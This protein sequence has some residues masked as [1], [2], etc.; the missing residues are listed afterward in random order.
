MPNWTE[1]QKKV[2]DLRN[3]N[4]LVSAAAGSG[5]TAVLVERIVS[6][7]TDEKNKIDIDHLLIVTFTNAAAAEMRERIGQAI[8][9]K[10]T[11]QL[12]N[13]HLQK[14]QTLIH[15]AQITTIHSFCLNVIRNNFNIIELDPSF[16]VGDETEL[17]LLKSDI[18]S[19]LLEKHYEQKD[20]TFYDFIESY[21]TGKTDIDIEN[22]ILQLYTFSQS[23]PEPK[24]WLNSLRK[25]FDINTVEDLEQTEW[26]KFLLDYIKEVTTEVGVIVDEAL[27]MCQEEDGAY[28]YLPT[29]MSDKALIRNLNSI[30]SY[31]AYSK[32]LCSLTW[33]PLS[34]KKDENV[35]LE[36]REATK[37]LR[38]EIKANIDNIRKNYFFQ[39]SDG[40][41]EDI[42]GSKSIMNVLIDLT[43]E[44]SQTYAEAKITKNILDFN[45]LEHK[46]LNILAKNNPDG[47]YSPTLTAYDLSEYYEEIV[48]D[49]YQDSN[50]VQEILL[51]SISREKFGQPN[52]FMVGDVK[53]SI[54]KF[55]LAKPEIFM[56]KYNNYLENRDLYYLVDLHKNFRSR[57]NIIECVNFIFEQIMDIK[58]GGINYN[59]KVALNSGAEFP[60]IDNNY[61]T[62][63][64]IVDLSVDILDESDKEEFDYTSKEFEAKA[65]AGKIKSIVASNFQVYDKDIKSYRNVKYK[66]IVILLRTVTGWADIFESVLMREGIAAHCDTSTGYF[67]TIEIQTV[68][69][70]LNIIDN[71]RQDIALVAVLKSPIAQINSE[72]LAI[73]K[74]EFV[75]KNMYDCVMNYIEC[76]SKKEI[77][78]KLADFINLLNKFRDCVPYTSIH[79]LI[80]YILDET[81]YYNYV[82]AMP[83]GSKRKAN[84]DMLIERAIQFEATSYKGL[85]NFIRYIDRIRDYQIDFGEA[86]VLGDNENVVKI[87]SIHKSKG[88]E[89]PIVFVSGLNK[90]FNNQ[91]ARSKIVIHSDLGI[92]PNY[93]D[94][95]LRVKS[96]TL[97]KKII[98]KRIVLENLGEELRIL[99]VALTRAKERLILTGATK[100][101][102]KMLSKYCEMVKQHSSTKLPFTLLSSA[103]TYLDW[104]IPSLL[105][106]N[107]FDEI[108][109]EKNIY[110]NKIFTKYS[111][112]DF[113]TKI[114][115]LSQLVTKE[116]QSQ[117]NKEIIKEKLLN[118]KTEIIDNDLH[119][120]I[121]KRLNWNYSHMNEVNLHAKMTV[122]E[123]KVMGQNV[124]NQYS[125]NLISTQDVTTPKFISHVIEIKGSTR[126]TVVHK[127]MQ[128]INFSAIKTL[129]DVDNQLEFLIKIN[130]LTEQEKTL[131]SNREIYNF[132][133][134]PLANRMINAEACGKIFKEKQFI[135]G[136]KACD[137]NINF[138]SNELVLVQGIIDVYFE[139][140]NNI[141]LVDYKTDKVE[142]EIILIDRYKTQLNYYQ[143][144]VEQI[145]G[146]KVIQKI[147]YSFSMCRE[148]LL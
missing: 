91:D 56:E 134:S 65:I 20:E 52:I 29:L 112:A 102:T 26:M 107:S 59:D 31:E 32:I 139:E 98:S 103:T 123:L 39:L 110:I 105:R 44:F 93:I 58:L 124:D 30:N 36:K 116:L 6:I 113:K 119:D 11:A 97:I 48:I 118:W 106:H 34:P 122:T 78:N 3:G 7:I 111:K 132:I 129:K 24:D 40:M 38:A 25:A 146:R 73:I 126:G 19:E 4:I 28:M 108:L 147:I 2:V 84:I 90:E 55:R 77:Q 53:Q 95:K 143:K 61:S 141:V 130:K 75:R 1:E 13:S 89:F 46:A 94:Y 82:S 148:I 120:E 131:V 57:K 18:V 37:S 66:D 35:S 83:V 135:I 12:S 128:N 80:E 63:L 127:V 45:D 33:A 10:L 5:K 100:N 47:S 145:T 109:K 49:E 114:I 104:I 21:S 72:E 79:H 60:P 22:L 81:D 43:I 71:P 41:I 54:Y 85:F 136:I 74:S 76:G 17:K 9:T 27:A 42:M 64:M 51:N 15:N 96:P 67:S 101:W 92:G 115:D 138:K 62:E 86:S 23:Y 137:I 99:Y 16:R 69:S 125:Q 144:A 140:D 14:Q 142:N 117:I 121:E 8:E 133:K 50:L 68:L 70:I 87:M 88:L